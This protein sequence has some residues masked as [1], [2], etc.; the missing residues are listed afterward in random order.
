MSLTGYLYKSVGVMADFSGHYASRIVY[1]Q[2]WGRS[3]G[4]NVE[5]RDF[6]TTIR[7]SGANFSR[8]IDRKA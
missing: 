4:V 6:A 3:T 7:V 2:S 1:D 8:R 5:N